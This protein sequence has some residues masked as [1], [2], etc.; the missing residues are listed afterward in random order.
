MSEFEP[1]DF[2]FEGKSVYIHSLNPSQDVHYQWLERIEFHDSFKAN[3]F[4]ERLSEEEKAAF[5]GHA[6]KEVVDVGTASKTCS[7][8]LRSGQRPAYYRDTA[9]S[10]IERGVN[11]TCLLL[12]PDSEM[13]DTYSTLRNE[14]LKKK[15][16]ES[17]ERFRTFAES[18]SGMRGEF[19]VLLYSLL[20]YFACIGVDR[21][22][23]GSVD[24]LSLHA[25]QSESE[26]RPS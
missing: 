1:L 7:Y 5:I 25:K 22:D 2:G 14:D 4:P 23:F 24:P 17:L 13:M 26:N 21:K 8:Y 11:Y 15:T 9:L 6:Q 16:L 19:K 10:L 20:P 3:V 18:V 12:N